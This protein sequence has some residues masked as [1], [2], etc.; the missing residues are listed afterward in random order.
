MVEGYDHILDAEDDDKNIFDIV[1]ERDNEST[2]KV[3]QGISAFEVS[4]FFTYP[5]MDELNV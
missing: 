5:L 4:Y 3:L 1:S 2:L